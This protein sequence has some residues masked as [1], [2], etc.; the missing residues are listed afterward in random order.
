MAFTQ[1]TDPMDPDPSGGNV[2][3]SLNA[4]A[5]TDIN[6]NNE[7]VVMIMYHTDFVADETRLNTPSTTGAFVNIDG[8]Q[9][10]MTEASGTTND[11]L[12]GVSYTD[13]TNA[14]HYADT[15]GNFDEFNKQPTTTNAKIAFIRQNNTIN[16]PENLTV[17]VVA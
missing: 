14:T 12:I 7:L 1:Y 6:A 10:H 15:S 5:I 8:G 3:I 9:M 2:N 13:G 11:P 4:Q 16:N 17:G